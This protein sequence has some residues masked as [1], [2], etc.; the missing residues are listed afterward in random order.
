MWL[1]PSIIVLISVLHKMDYITCSMSVKRCYL[2]PKI[3][4]FMFIFCRFHK[5]L[6]NCVFISSVNHKLSCL[7]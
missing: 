4:I 1:I 6:K 5:C 2:F 3:Y 7:T